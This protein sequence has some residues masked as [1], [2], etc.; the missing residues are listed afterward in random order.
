MRPFRFALESVR[1]LREQAETEA[2]YR[3]ARELAVGEARAKA[4]READ[5]ALRSAVD[6]DLLAA[7][8]VSAAQLASREVFLERRERERLAADLLAQAQDERIAR[9][10]QAYE[11]AAQER[12]SLERLKARRLS[13]HRRTARLE[14][15]A[16]IIE[17]AL[18]RHGRGL[19]GS[20]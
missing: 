1:R 20:P 2:K 14:L 11:S 7:G 9:E 13:A 10:R 4:L 19:G 5:A 12:A 16:G 8:P 3:L 17:A 6:T 15:Q 18:L